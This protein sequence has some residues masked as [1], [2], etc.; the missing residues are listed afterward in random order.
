MVR[1]MSVIKHAEQVS[2]TCVTTKQRRRPFPQQAKYRAQEQLELIHGNLCRAVT[3][4]TPGGRCYFLLLVDD[5][6]RFMWAVMLPSKDAAT[7]AIKHVLAV[8][9]KESGRKLRVLRIDNGSEFTVAEFADYYVGEG[10]QRHFSAPYSPQQ[11]GVVERRNRTVVAT[12]RSLLKQRRMPTKYWGEA[13]MTAVHLL[14]RSPTWSLQG[15]TP[16]E[17]WHGRTP[18]VS[19]L[20]RSAASPTPRTWVS[21]ASLMTAASPTSSSGTRREPRRTAS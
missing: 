14:N 10:I 13:V 5:V 18:V 11:N 8:A 12:A 1:G 4:A 17:A 3:S 21:S 20:K 9:E 16:Y 15:K 19:H 2:D 7:D 6:S